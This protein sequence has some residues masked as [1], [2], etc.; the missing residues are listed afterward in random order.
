M[1]LP[2][3]LFGLL[4][5]LPSMR[6]ENILPIKTEYGAKFPVPTGA[7]VSL[8]LPEKLKLGDA[9]SGTFTVK[10]T[11]D[12]PF[13]ISTGGDYRG[14]GFPLRLK[15]RVSDSKGGVLPDTTQGLP[16]LGGMMA[17]TKITPGA[18]HDISFPLA[19]YVTLPGAGI[20][21]V[22]AC[23]DL[24]WLVDDTHSHPVAKTKIEILL[25]TANEA[26]A[27]VR[28]LCTGGDPDKRFQLD[29][30]QHGVFLPS[31]ILEAEA[32]NA[33]AV[34][35]I[36]GIPGTAALEALLHLL[37]NPS[38][39]VVKAAGN[40]L[41][42]RLPSLSNPAKTAFS[43]W[44]DNS[45]AIKEWHPKYH[46]PLLKSALA[47]LRSKDAAAVELGAAFIQAQG[48]AT[49]AKPLLDATQTALD[50]PWAVRSGKGA[51]VLDPPPPLRGLIQA[52][53][54]LRA[55]GWSLGPNTGGGTAVILARFRELA[56]PKMPRP[57]DDRWKETI[58]AFIDANPPTFRQNAILAIPTPVD[59]KFE[60]ALMKALEDK[61]WAV[62]RSACE[63]AGKSE[64]KPFIRP[65]CQIVETIHETFVQAAASSS[66]YNLGARVEL[67]D[68]WCE[69]LTDQDF[70]DEALSQLTRGTLDLSSNSGGGNSNFTREQRFAIRDAWRA[71]LA[72]NRD[73]LARG[74]RVPL[75]DPSVTPSLTGINFDP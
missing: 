25:P 40:E 75:N 13:E 1:K 61:D 9:I 29:K 31:L 27:R 65:L 57:A 11:G 66:A 55:R 67:W 45:A 54:T 62:L 74:E 60:K 16:D 15:I 24:G 52:L 70:M 73:R 3:L 47:L 19:G 8:T 53:D 69:V 34:T 22:E 18:T 38:P 59:D 17:P 39:D 41:K 35:G 30:L 2:H 4:L 43:P 71:F 32:G 72:K 42:F 6:A 12:Q 50:G 37:E 48:D 20:F 28:G 51:N 44:S 23:H 58:L 56:D 33:D 14:T 26:A 64:R 46:E 49:H 10:N 21:T 68:A 63:V 5:T 36:N 7:V